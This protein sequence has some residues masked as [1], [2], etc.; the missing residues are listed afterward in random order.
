[1]IPSHLLVTT[2]V[3]LLKGSLNRASVCASS[4]HLVGHCLADRVHLVR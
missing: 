3:L 4:V 2:L 1:M